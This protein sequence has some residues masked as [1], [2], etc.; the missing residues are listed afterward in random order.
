MVSRSSAHNAAARDKLHRE[1]DRRWTRLERRHPELAETIRYGR[2]LVTLFID[3][4]PEAP[5]FAL[6]IEQARAKLTSGSPL[7]DDEALEL[8]LPALRRFATLLCA[9]AGEQEVL[10]PAARVIAQALVTDTLTIDDLLGVA[11]ADDVAMA[12][13]LTA[14][15]TLDPALLATVAALTLSAGLMGLA[16]ELTPFLREAAIQWDMPHC[17]ICGGV[18]LLAE[19]QGSGGERMLRCAT[20]GGGWRILI[21]QCGHCGTNDS[22]ALHYLA[23]EGEEGKYRIDLCERCRGA[24]KGVATFTATPP[25]LLLIEDTALLHLLHEAEARG[26][27]TTPAIDSLHTPVEPPVTPPLAG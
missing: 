25:E 9:W 5:P 7:L 26:Y 4:R 24:M 8:D 20:C 19:L 22:A 15:L 2:R 17:P 14:R 11:T 1:A 23:A 12:V 3:E 18:P 27:T 6:T 21:S 16:Q 13:T 10:A